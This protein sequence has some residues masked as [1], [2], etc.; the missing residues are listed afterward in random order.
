V[1]LDDDDRNLCD[2]IMR[3]GRLQAVPSVELILGAA[4]TLCNGE[5]IEFRT[6]GTTRQEK[7]TYPPG[8]TK[9]QRR[10]LDYDYDRGRR[11]QG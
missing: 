10:I 6:C 8:T 7:P 1:I 5:R 11:D 3:H 4:R 9:L 2:W